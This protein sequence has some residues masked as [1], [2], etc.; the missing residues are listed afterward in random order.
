[1][2]VA[3]LLLI[4]I[5]IMKIWPETDAAHWLHRI[6]VAQ[7]VTVLATVTRQKIIFGVLLFVMLIG[8]AEL[9]APQLITAI[10]F[11]FSVF[12]DAVITVW[13]VA[14]LTRLRGSRTAL[15]ARLHVTG[16]R[17]TRPR[18]RRR[19]RDAMAM[20]SGANDDEHPGAFAR[21]A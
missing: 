15:R 8:F 5:L 6:M 21:V 17:Q 7:P 12:Y 19:Q 9:G 16:L 20:R 11:D 4:A 13:T 14:A 1:M 2:T 3:G 10:A 18:R